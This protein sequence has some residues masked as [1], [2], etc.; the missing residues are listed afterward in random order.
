[1]P[2]IVGTLGF[3]RMGPR[4]ELTMALENY[5]TRNS[6]IDAL[7]ADVRAL[8]A[9]TWARQVGL[10]V[11]HPP[12]NDFSLHD[13]LLDASVLVGAIPA[14]YGWS[15]GQVPL[16]TYFAMAHGI[17]K[18]PGLETV[19]WFDTHYHCVAPQLTRSQPFTLASTK[20][21][22]EFLEARALGIHTRPVLVGPVTWLTFGRSLDA[23]LDPLSLLPGLLPV[24]VELLRRLAA[25]GADWV[26]IDEPCLVLDLD[27]R[28]RAALRTTYRTLAREVPRV[29]LL[30]TTYFGGLG[31]NLGTALA[32]PVA[33]LH[34]DLV[35]APG[36]LAQALDRRPRDLSLSL[37][38]VDGRNVWRADLPA[39]LDLLEPALDRVGG[40]RLMLG[41]SCSLLHVPIDLDLETGL[42][43]E[44]KSW[45]AF[46][47]QKAEELTTLAR[48]LTEGRGAVRDMLDASAAAH[49]SRCRSI[50][51]HDPLVRE[52][53]ASV[54][55]AMT[56][57]PM[58]VAD[59]RSV[60]RKRL[61][62]PIFPTTTIGSL[63]Q[64]TELRDAQSRHARGLLS[65]A[66]YTAILRRETKAA[67]RWQEEIGLDVLVHGAFERDDGV[68]YFAERLSGFAITRHG[69]IQSR[70]AQCVRPP[71]IFGDVSRP[72]R[73]TVEW[74]AYAQSLTG[75]PVKGLLTG[76]VTLLHES[77]V[78][79]DRPPMEVCRQIALAI[80]DETIDLET[81][82][83]AVIQID[84]PAIHKGLPLRQDGRASYLA[85][86]TENFRL[87]SS[88]VADDTQIHAHL[89]DSGISDLLDVITVM[90]V[91]VIS[92]AAARSQMRALEAVV[93]CRA[94]SE[95]GPGL[96]DVQALH[97]PTVGEMTAL[98]NRASEWL[99]ADRIW[100]NPD[101]GLRTRSW[102]EARPALLNMVA[103]AKAARCPF[104]GP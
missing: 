64:T 32:L 40:D 71:V 72:V 31:D 33:G 92:M 37:G 70:G 74:N 14:N 59:R 69:W 63:P 50:R 57:R 68:E 2:V 58:S 43:T 104:A 28:T 27:E 22:D 18:R 96:Y 34:L 94:P 80:R 8:R 86:A 54:T 85:L 47:V 83:I 100:V 4:R 20:P 51:V 13:H 75:Q 12:S 38:I 56:R 73:M 60:Q 19:R 11:T 95:I 46:A 25:A 79:D 65:D 10:G 5:R 77:F 87:A 6:G 62:L 76:P 7:Q 15:G 24:Y 93:A 23:E 53:V 21:V 29:K 81:A 66:A 98:L 78:R 99:Y 52:R 30:L 39:L 90:D 35:R 61:P 49:D 89:C 41:P 101:C 67:V 45:L 55:A 3:P 91:D 36:Q 97:C 44:F 103:A 16:S 17:D 102:E 84:E 26:Q 88:G 1:M 82:G 9:A 42:D 48:A